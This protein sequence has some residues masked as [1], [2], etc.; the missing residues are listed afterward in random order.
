MYR[1]SL[2]IQI[3]FLIS[4]LMFITACGGGGADFDPNQFEEPDLS[5][6][7]FDQYS[8]KTTPT[9]LVSGDLSPFSSVIFSDTLG[10]FNTDSSNTS[11]SSNINFKM[12]S[13]INVRNI[14]KQSINNNV[15]SRKND[16]NEL[17]NCLVSG[18]ESVKGFI[19]DDFTGVL[20]VA[21]DHCNNGEVTQ[22]GVVTIN[23]L[24]GITNNFEAVAFYQKV[25]ITEGNS[26]Y[27]L[28]GRLHDKKIVNSTLSELTADMVITDQDSLAQLKLE[29]YVTNS[30]EFCSGDNYDQYMRGR[31]YH[32]DYGYVDV[33][34]VQTLKYINGYTGRP[35]Y[36][37]QIRLEGASGGSALIIFEYIE[38]YRRSTIDEKKYLVRINL[39]RDGDHQYETQNVFSSAIA[40]QYEVYD[41]GDNDGDGMPN[42]WERLYGFDPNSNLDAALDADNDGFTNQLEFERYGNPL[43][44]T[45]APIVTELSLE[46][47]PLTNIVRA[48]QPQEIWV[49]ITN[50]N[51]EYGATGVN[52]TLTKSP[53]V[54]WDR[55]HG[56]LWREINPN[57]MNCYIDSIGQNFG[58][59]VGASIKGE[60]E[61][62]TMMASVTSETFDNDQSNNSDTLSAAFNQREARIGLMPNYSFSQ[63]PHYDVA[64]I[65]NTH[66]FDIHLSHWGP[67]NAYN[68]IFRMS[69]PNHVQ[70]VSASYVINGISAG[71]CNIDTEI[72]CN[73]GTIYNSGA[74][75]KGYVR[76]EVT[77]VTQGY[78]EYTASLIS[79]AINTEPTN[80]SFT[81]QMFVGQSLAPMQV[82]IDNA[83]G[84]VDINLNA[85]MY[86]GGL[87]FYGK[88]VTLNG[89][90][91][92]EA[93]VIR[94]VS[95]VDTLFSSFHVGSDSI[96]RN[97]YF[98]GR[99][100]N[101]GSAV[102]L[103]VSGS[104]LH[105]ENNIFE[106]NGYNNVGINGYADDVTIRGNTFRYSS[107]PSSCSLIRLE[108]NGSYFI[109][110]NLIHDTDCT[111]ISLS[112]FN[113]IPETPV[114]HIVT[115]NTIVNNASGI[116]D[117]VV[118]Q[119]SEKIIQNNILVNNQQGLGISLSSIV[120][121]MAYPYTMPQI[122]N[123]LI[124]GNTVDVLTHEIIVFLP[125]DNGLNLNQD[126][127]FIDM[128][129]FNYRLDLG[130]PAIDAGINTNTPLID[131]EQSVR[132]VDGNMDTISEIDIGA[133][134]YQP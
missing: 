56:C 102:V 16:I 111:A 24:N 36:I 29:N 50:P 108:G 13:V 5:S 126:P 35:E 132:P 68:S 117:G 30:C 54:E 116:S 80:N 33:T 63:N 20:E 44:D 79:D 21:Y 1:V 76:I 119:G 113:P 72:V 87:N 47:R 118:L 31:I 53:N 77:G 37:G 25:L 66:A 123:N 42:G 67:D 130:S 122:T 100:Y 99:D 8:G 58:R 15:M 133:Y 26:R 78:G 48:D 18:S 97:I 41:I 98:K 2:W 129:N 27:S 86:V 43:D 62:Y 55:T 17:N 6:S 95:P 73:M 11:I 83:S 94:I 90:S 64:T 109:D 7:L 65:G 107:S 14:K 70:V 71:A 74:S 28:S 93:T 49:V 103:S 51:P 120:E 110:N 128:A 88:P 81:T 84:A 115:N 91:T 82:Q 75:T 131:I 38:V 96:V 39:D 9:S 104:N 92:P 69:L 60:A 34:T 19:N 61:E 45:V 125:F 85:G 57:Q 124:F 59:A 89:S 10:F 32:S 114:T 101:F 40:H 106:H 4:L 23:I 105:I 112:S 3:S 121:Y 127:L 134:E 52:V 12:S 22:H 46:F